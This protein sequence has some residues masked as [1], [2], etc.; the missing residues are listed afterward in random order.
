MLTQRTELSDTTR[1][2]E[3]TNEYMQEILVHEGEKPTDSQF[4]LYR[5]RRDYIVPTMNRGQK[6]RFELLNAA[7][8]EEQPTIWLEILQKGIKCKFRIAHQLFMGVPQPTAALVGSAIGFVA[9]GLILFY[10]NSFWLTG[11][12]SYVIGLFA[13]IPG[14]FAVKSYRKIRN[15]FTG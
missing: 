12:L 1:I 3:F 11:L 7:K 15:W 9:I 14:V 13:L 6:V 5:C 10:V 4:E 8:T 2:I